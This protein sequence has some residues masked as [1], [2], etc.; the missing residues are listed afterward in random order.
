MT[1]ALGADGFCALGIVP[2]CLDGRCKVVCLCACVLKSRCEI[3]CLCV[4]K[5]GGNIVFVLGCSWS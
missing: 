3:L 4:R 2:G 1:G 5:L